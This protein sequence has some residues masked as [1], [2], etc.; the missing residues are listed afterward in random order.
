MSSGGSEKTR[1]RLDKWLWAARFYKTRALAQEAVD[2]G[3]VHYE[4]QRAKSS[5]DVQVGA[6][7]TV[8]VGHDSRDIVVTALADKRGSAA[9]AALLYTETPD[10]IA[11]REAAAAQRRALALTDPTPDHRPDKRERRQMERFRS[12]NDPSSHGRP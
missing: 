6:H 3:R 12:R 7:L 8:V 11:R 1:T 5:R 2:G 10:S 9:Q 4:G